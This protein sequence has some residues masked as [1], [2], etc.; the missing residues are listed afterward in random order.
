MDRHHR[1]GLQRGE[2]SHLAVEHGVVSTPAPNSSTGQAH[3]CG[4]L[5]WPRQTRRIQDIYCLI[6]LIALRSQTTGSATDMS[7]MW[8][9]SSSSP[10]VCG[11]K[12]ASRRLFWDV[13][14]FPEGFT[15]LLLL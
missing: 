5:H 10:D 3:A 14:G 4:L 6:L 12:N 13:E 2:V 9:W 11:P 8:S 7:L 1:P 15:N